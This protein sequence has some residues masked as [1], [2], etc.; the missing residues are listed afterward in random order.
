MIYLNDI[1][2]QQGAFI[3][4]K[5]CTLNLSEGTIVCKCLGI[6]DIELIEI[7][8]IKKITCLSELKLE[9]EAGSGC[10]A[11]HKKLNQIILENGPMTEA[12]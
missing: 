1:G 8:R 5:T 11:C 12:V 9:T 6:S 2:S 4:M 3:H 10:T 7:T